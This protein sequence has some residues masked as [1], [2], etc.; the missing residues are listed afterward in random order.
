MLSLTLWLIVHAIKQFQ[1]KE[2]N[3]SENQ[4]QKLDSKPMTWKGANTFCVTIA[5]TRE[6]V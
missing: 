5:K 1:S 4:K 3:R 6:K 2:K